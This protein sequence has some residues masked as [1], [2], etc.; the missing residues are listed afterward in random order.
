[1]TGA[2]LALVLQTAIQGADWHPPSTLDL[3]REARATRRE[4]LRLGTVPIRR[5]EPAARSSLAT[6][7]PVNQPWRPVTEADLRQRNAVPTSIYK[8]KLRY[9]V[10]IAVDYDGDGTTDIAR[11]VENSRQAGIE[12][13]FGERQAASVIFRMEG[14]WVQEELLPAGRRRI[15]LAKP[16]LGYT[17]FFRQ[18]GADR[19]YYSG[20]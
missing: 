15:Y 18:A 20:D 2:T 13:R 5:S 9:S 3:Q 10:Q 17:L 14:R 16:E 8:N 11:L 19:A 12:V 1:M 7:N 6:V 4:A